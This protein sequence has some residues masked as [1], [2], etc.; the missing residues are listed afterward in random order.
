MLTW[1]FVVSM[2]VC[3]FFIQLGSLGSLTRVKCVPQPSWTRGAAV[4]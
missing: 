3:P 2:L 4:V 1:G